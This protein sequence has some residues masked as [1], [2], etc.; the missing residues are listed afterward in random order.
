MR[1]QVCV[2]FGTLWERNSR[3]A[4]IGNSAVRLHTPEY[5]VTAPSL[6]QMQS[7]LIGIV[8]PPKSKLYTVGGRLQGIYDSREYLRY[9]FK[10]LE[11]VQFVM[12][13]AY[14]TMSKSRN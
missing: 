6:G 2:I 11:A 12:A 7:L 5:S 13:E 10:S 3:T 1:K 14:L 4:I 9:S 8:L